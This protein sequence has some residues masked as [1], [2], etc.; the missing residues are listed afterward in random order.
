MSIYGAD[1]EEDF[2]ILKDELG[3][4]FTMPTAKE[5]MRSLPTNI[6]A[7]T[8][9]TAPGMDE[10]MFGR[11]LF[12]C[13]MT[14]MRVAHGPYSQSLRRVVEFNIDIDAFSMALNAEQ[15]GNQTR[16]DEIEE[17]IGTPLERPEPSRIESLYE[18][19]AIIKQREMEAE[20]DDILE[21]LGDSKRE[22][23]EAARTKEAS[24]MAIA[25]MRKKYREDA[26]VEFVDKDAKYVADLDR[27]SSVKK[28][29]TVKTK[30]KDRRTVLDI[31][32]QCI[33]LSINLISSFIKAAVRS[34]PVCSTKLSQSVVLE[35]TG[36][37][38]S[39]PYESSNLSGMYQILKINYATAS[40]VNFNYQLAETLSIKISEKEFELNPMKVIAMVEGA[41]AIW[42]MMGYWT[43]M[44]EDIFFC[45]V[46]MAA[47]PQGKIRDLCTLEMSRFFS[48]R[49]E[50][51]KK[52]LRGPGA[53]DEGSSQLSSL[54]YEEEK[55]SYVHL[56][57]YLESLSKTAAM[58]TFSPG[59]VTGS[60]S[61]M[62]AGGG[63]AVG[64][65]GAVGGGGK[66]GSS[67]GYGAGGGGGKLT[68]PSKFGFRQD[69]EQAHAA[70]VELSTDQ[71]FTGEVTSDKNMGTKN[72]FNGQLYRYTATQNPCVPCNHAE[73]K[74]Y[75]LE[76]R[77][78]HLYGHKKAQCRQNVSE[79]PTQPKK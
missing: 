38:I 67:T 61:G 41:M 34:R 51:S 49:D 18:G 24:D 64:D 16:L 69:V 58:K 4:H 6:N 79:T 31:M 71:M 62:K 27:R 53:S 36:E 75:G 68:N 70:L 12:A 2:K 43:Y 77:K 13:V 46:T 26:L 35:M 37:R 76:C 52:R 29:L 54:V 11:K 9:D 60:G 56:K 32:A 73:P 55:S 66:A 33:K 14:K 59:G 42:N 47:L 74:C 65:K 7:I 44:T 63:G 40:F 57:T 20:R 19:R 23:E 72:A 28:E 1:R 30:D 15:T 22:K 17:L 25:A 50:Q 21:T 10:D 45:C 5:F 39:N 78:C 3:A 48:E 8:V